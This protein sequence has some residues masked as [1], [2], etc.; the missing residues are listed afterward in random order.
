MV[1]GIMSQQAMHSSA[2]LLYHQIA[3]MRCAIRWSFTSFAFVLE[4]G[5]SFE[6]TEKPGL[7]IAS[8]VRD[9]SFA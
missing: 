2:S 9:M 8:A 6:N 3:K 1:A 7:H 5:V 4:E